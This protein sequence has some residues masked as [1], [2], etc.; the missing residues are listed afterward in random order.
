MFVYRRNLT[1]CDAG[2]FIGY[3]LNNMNGIHYPGRDGMHPLCVSFYIFQTDPEF[4]VIFMVIRNHSSSWFSSNAA[5]IGQ[6]VCFKDTYGFRPEQDEKSYQ[7]AISGVYREQL[8]SAMAVAFP[9]ARFIWA[10][11]PTK[12]TWK[13]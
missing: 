12:F 6:H 1:Y 5:F 10:E 3:G 7:R 4:F 2:M 9:K 11:S 13:H 8:I